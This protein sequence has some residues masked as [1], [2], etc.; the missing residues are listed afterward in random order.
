MKMYLILRVIL[1][2]HIAGFVIMAGT[3]TIDFFTFKTFWKFAGDGKSLGLLPLM[4]KYGTF[5]RTGGITV[6]LTGVTMFLLTKGIWWSHS[7]FRIKMLL[8]ALLVLNGIL[9]GNKQGHQLRE[10]VRQ[11]PT[12]FIAHTTAVKATLHW[13]YLIQ[14]TIFFSI[15]LLTVVKLDK[16]PD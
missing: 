6:L 7:W 3:T 5:V 14:L 15:L 11:H 10:I 2:L 1:A 13:F 12:D 8:V 9:V 16:I 4:E